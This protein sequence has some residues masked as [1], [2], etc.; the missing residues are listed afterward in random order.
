MKIAV[1]F[2][3]MKLKLFSVYLCV[4]VLYGIIFAG[5]TLFFSQAV[6]FNLYDNRIRI[7]FDFALCKN[8]TGEFTVPL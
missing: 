8:T 5:A 2:E 3:G 4:R 1:Y 7:C 6:I